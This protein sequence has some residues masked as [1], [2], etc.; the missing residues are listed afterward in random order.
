MTPRKDERCVRWETLGITPTDDGLGA[1]DVGHE[2]DG[3]TLGA[4]GGGSSRISKCAPQLSH[5]ELQTAAFRVAMASRTKDGALSLGTSRA[6]TTQC[7]WPAPVDEVTCAG[8]VLV[9]ART[10]SASARS[11]RVMA[12]RLVWRLRASASSEV[13]SSGV[14]RT[15]VGGRSFVTRSPPG[16]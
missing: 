5:S 6:T 3:L 4:G 14:K 12:D 8:S 9:T 15:V 7:S 10:V 13:S 2:V 11:V 16:G 1:D